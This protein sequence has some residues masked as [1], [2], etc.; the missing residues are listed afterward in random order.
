MTS[1]QFTNSSLQANYT[2]ASNPDHY[3]G[4]PN[5]DTTHPL[6]KQQC[7]NALSSSDMMG[8]WVRQSSIGFCFCDLCARQVGEVHRPAC[9]F[10]G[11]KVGNLNDQL[12]AADEAVIEIP[13]TWC[14]IG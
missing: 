10:S 11:G 4:H 13:S 3:I 12:V 1:T 9:R 6:T 2:Y 7:I 8:G 5:W 14:V